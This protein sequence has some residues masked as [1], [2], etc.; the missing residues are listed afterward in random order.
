MQQNFCGS[1]LCFTVGMDDLADP[2]VTSSPVVA[3]PMILHDPQ[4]P[5]EKPL[6]T[7]G[8]NQ[9]RAAS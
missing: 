1:V 6:S 9:L 7:S 2:F 5:I 3:H 8:S 4:I